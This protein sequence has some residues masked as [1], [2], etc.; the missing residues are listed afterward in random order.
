ML[1]GAG[2]DPDARGSEGFTA[3]AVGVHFNQPPV[4][5][6]LIRVGAAMNVG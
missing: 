2:V 3:L 1:L 6:L 4:V 5:E